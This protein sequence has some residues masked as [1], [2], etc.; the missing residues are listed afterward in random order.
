MWMA[1]SPPRGKTMTQ[2]HS[3][4]RHRPLLARLGAQRQC[5]RRPAARAR[6][7]GRAA[8]GEHHHAR[9]LR[10]RGRR[11]EG[12]EDFLLHLAPLARPELGA[13]RTAAHRRSAQA[14]PACARWWRTRCRRGAARTW[15][16]PSAAT[17]DAIVDGLRARDGEA[18]DAVAR[19]HAALRLQGAARSAS[20]C[21]RRAA[22]TCTPSAT[23]CGP[24]W[25][26]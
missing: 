13:A 7:G 5:G 21:R 19:H 15:P 14:H 8:A 16:K 24:P 1:A 22:S 26:R 11:P 12:L 3:R 23:W 9:S 25:V 18:I 6:A 10:A 4:I 2:D 17:R 20:A